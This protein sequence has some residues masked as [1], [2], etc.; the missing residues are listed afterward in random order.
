MARTGRNEYRS[1]EYRRTEDRRSVERNMYVYDNLAR[2]QD[3]VRTLEEEPRRSI[4]NEARKNREKAHH[5][6]LAYVLFLIAA[7]CCTGVILVNY[8]QIQ[9]EVTRK[10]EVIASLEKDLNDLRLSNDEEYNRILSSVDMEEI[11]RIAIGELGMTY[12]REGQIQTYT[13]EGNDYMR[14]VAQD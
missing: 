5:M 1:S 6:N 4:S 11:K 7:L 14:R 9:S 12:A 13:N 10:A 2:S 8:L 3:F